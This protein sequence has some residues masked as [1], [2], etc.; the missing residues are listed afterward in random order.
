MMRAE[1]VD[2]IERFASERARA[3]E[4]DENELWILSYYRASELAG[5][6]VMGR[7]AS[8]TDDDDLRVHLTEHCAEEANHAWLWTRTILDVGGT[9]RR[10]SETYQSRYYEAIGPPTTVLEVLALTQVFE[11]RVVKHFRDHLRKPGTHPAVQRTLERMIADEAGHIGWVKKRLD[12]W[13]SASGETAVTETLRRFAE[14]DERV[15]A[16]LVEYRDRFGELVDPAKAG[17]PAAEMVPTQ[18]ARNGVGPGRSRT[19][20]EWAVRNLIAK[21]LGVRPQDLDPET[22]LGMLGFESLDLLAIISTIEEAFRIEF[23]PADTERLYTLDDLI[24]TVAELATR[25]ENH[26]RQARRSR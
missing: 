18:A 14:V 11:K 9:P 2:P 1:S 8:Q 26:E 10:V 20:V 24:G 5:A 15:Y 19:S 25:R 23:S 4:I 6:L 21:S 7:L 22:P 3:M 16:G 13:T 12:G 17:N